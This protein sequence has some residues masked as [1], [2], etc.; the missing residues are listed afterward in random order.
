MNYWLLIYSALF[1]ATWWGLSSTYGKREGTIAALIFAALGG[2]SLLHLDL[3]LIGGL[4]ATGLA[5][6]FL[7]WRLNLKRHGSF[8]ATADIAWIIFVVLA[9]NY[10]PDHKTIFAFVERH[11]EALGA[12]WQGH[13]I[14]IVTLAVCF[15]CM[16][17]EIARKRRERAKRQAD[18][19]WWQA[20]AQAA[21]AKA[22]FEAQARDAAQAR[23]WWDEN[24]FDASDPPTPSCPPSPDDLERAHRWR[25]AERKALLAIPYEGRQ[26]TLPL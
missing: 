17:L 18:K 1:F 22:R 5:S 4:T 26:L 3:P 20:H 6:Y 21:Q 2:L 24:S 13:L 16:L 19:A 23:A 12:R 15:A 7:L 25:D 8:R 9:L 11:W 14:L 10:G